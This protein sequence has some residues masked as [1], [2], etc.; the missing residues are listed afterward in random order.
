MIKTTKTTLLF[1]PNMHVICLRP[2][3]AAILDGNHMSHVA[4][5]AFIMR[6]LL[7]SWSVVML[8]DLGMEYMGKVR[9]GTV[10]IIAHPVGVNGYNQQD[11]RPGYHAS[12]LAS[13]LPKSFRFL[14]IPADDF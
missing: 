11:C 1:L 3:L 4:S 5:N 2:T 13:P 10:R 14:R 7:P 6:R 12:P 8:A 9:G